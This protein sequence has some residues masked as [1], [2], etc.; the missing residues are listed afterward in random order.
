MRI[1]PTTKPARGKMALVICAVG[2]LLAVSSESAAKPLSPK[3]LFARMESSSP[4]IQELN[5]Q[6]EFARLEFRRAAVILQ[7]SLSYSNEQLTTSAGT[8]RES[9]IGVSNDISFLWSRPSR[10]RAAQYSLQAAEA[11]YLQSNSEFQ[12]EVIIGCLRLNLL[13]L[14][15]TLIDSVANQ[16]EFLVRSAQGRAKAGELSDYQAERFRLEQTEILRLRQELLSG[17]RE[18]LINLISLT[19]LP[20]TDLRNGDVA[21]GDLPRLSPDSTVALALASNAR[22]KMMQ[23][24]EQAMRSSVTAASTG[25]LPK[26]EL[27]VGRRTS[28]GGGKGAVVELSASFDLLGQRGGEIRR[29]K[30][31]W[32]AAETERLAYE[33][34]IALETKSLIEQLSH[35][36]ASDVRPGAESAINSN[37]LRILYAQGEL[38]ASEL[39][40]MLKATIDSQKAQNSLLV[41]KIELELQ[42]RRLC[43]RGIIE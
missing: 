31:A 7:P 11:E 2:V 40:D 21:V 19:G 12:S 26:M 36:P 4:V 42:L 24:R 1:C 18:L 20:E 37:A 22:L 14:E 35:L 25:S 33:Q 38:S 29:A 30:A 16:V 28:T 34:Q 5:A 9:A 8:D 41:L 39:V 43:G 15:L 23:A 10:V 27:G 13:K 17:E 6:L 3:A 32:K